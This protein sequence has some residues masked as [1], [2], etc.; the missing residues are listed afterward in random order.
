MHFAVPVLLVRRPG[1]RH[2]RRV[3]REAIEDRHLRISNRGRVVVA[4]DLAHVCLAADEVEL[5]DLENLSFDH[6]DGLGMQRRERAGEIGF[7]DHLRTAGVIGD[8]EVV[9]RNRPQAHRVGRI[10]LA[11]PVPLSFGIFTAGPMHQAGFLQDAEDLLHVHLA[12]G[13]PGGERQLERRALHV[14]HEDVQV[15]GIHQRVLRRCVEEIRRM[16][17]D[18]LIDRRARCHHHRRR[19]SASSSSAPGALPRRR[20]RPRISGHHAH[21]ERTDVDAKFE[22]IGGDHAAYLPG[23]QPLLDLAATQRQVAA[24]IAADPL[25][26]A[27]HVLEIFLE[28]RRQD[29]RRQPALR[30]DD[31]LEVAAQEF[32]GDAARL[33]DVR[34][35]N[36]KLAIHDRWIHEHEKL[37][38]PR[39]AALLD[40]RKR[41]LRETLGELR[42]IRDRGR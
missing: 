32:A 35:P 39:R 21:V 19:L 29:L 31:D 10:R 30:K 24:A 15:V 33:G 22:R 9:R 36:A 20:D 6:V 26:H 42:G 40:E 14:I 3:L 11:G 38:A 5:F 37:L 25:R 16:L 7:A 12:V 28:I 2:L 18:E 17:R 34:T 8:H 4:I 13:L 1:G 41:F 23:A 27:R